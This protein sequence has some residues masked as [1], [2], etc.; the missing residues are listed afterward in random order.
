M[1]KRVKLFSKLLTRDQLVRLKRVGGLDAHAVNIIEKGRM[2]DAAIAFANWKDLFRKSS[3]SDRVKVK[4]YPALYQDHHAEKPNQAAHAFDTFKFDEEILGSYYDVDFIDPVIALSIKGLNTSTTEVPWY[5]NQSW[6]VRISNR[7]YSYNEELFEELANAGMASLDEAARILRRITSERE[8]A[9]ID[10]A[11]SL[12]DADLKHP[13][14]NGSYRKALLE[15]RSNPLIMSP[16]Q[17]L[18]TLGTMI[19]GGAETV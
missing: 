2:Y 4:Y 14:L 12:V 8:S 13:D 7:V 19:E 15:A 11:Q 1:I 9:L 6:D 18:K 16:E 5:M 10:V 17:A 3:L